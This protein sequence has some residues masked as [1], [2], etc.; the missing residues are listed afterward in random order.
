MAMKPNDT[1]TIPGSSFE[2][3]QPTLGSDFTAQTPTEHLQQSQLLGPSPLRD[4]SKY[5]DTVQYSPEKKPE[6]YAYIKEIENEIHDYRANAITIESQRKKSILDIWKLTR[7]QLTEDDLIEKE[8]VIAGKLFGNDGHLFWLDKKGASHNTQQKDIGDWFYMSPPKWLQPVVIHYET[9][10]SK[11][12]KLYMGVP[13][14]LSIQELENVCRAISQYKDMV[15]KELYSFDETVHEL[16]E[17]VDSEKIIIPDT[18]EEMFGK[19]AVERMV[20][21]HRESLQAQSQPVITQPLEHDTKDDYRR[22]A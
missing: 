3:P 6:L 19:E 5:A 18:A 10:S 13:Y 12:S 17:E 8:K 2:K 16:Q 9:H 14:Q 4:A 20:Q 21:Q 22:A 15:R 7:P 11:L 1:Y